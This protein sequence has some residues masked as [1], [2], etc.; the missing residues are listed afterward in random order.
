MAAYRGRGVHG[1]T[2]EILGTR[3][4][5]G[6]LAEGATLDI[7]GLGRELD[8][9]L[10]AL[11]EALKVLAAKGLLDARQKRGTFVTP[12]GGWNLLDADVMRWEF[13]GARRAALFADLAEVRA[14]VEP[15]C[16]EAAARRRTP[17]DLAALDRALDDMARAHTAGD[18]ARAAAAD[19]AFHRALY[20]ATHN[21]LFAR[22]DLFI[23]IPL[24]ERDRVVHAADADDPVPVHRAVLQAVRAGSPEAARDAVRV[25]LEKAARDLRAVLKG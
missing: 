13:A 21:E 8:V 14:A 12:R 20:T 25:L 7:A 3:I 22:M 18:P 2:V 10:T 24:A 5:S 9:S 1:R 16:A 6:E 15:A 17:A 4:V 23:E 19:L 11:R